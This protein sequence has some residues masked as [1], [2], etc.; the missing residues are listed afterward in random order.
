MI[1]MSRSLD[2]GKRR[3]EVSIEE[4]EELREGRREEREDSPYSSSPCRL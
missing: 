2:E 3:K 4:E 1:K